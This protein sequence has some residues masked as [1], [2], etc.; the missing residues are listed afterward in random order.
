[1]AINHYKVVEGV[2]LQ[3]SY[4]RIP[5]AAAIYRVAKNHPYVSN[6]YCKTTPKGD[7]LIFMTVD[8]EIADIVKNNIHEKE[9]IAIKCHKSDNRMPEVYALR[10]DFPLGLPH[11]N[12]VPFDHPVSLCVSDVPFQD[13]RTN[14]SAFSFIELI[15]RW[16]S[17][18]AIG[19]L[20]EKD[21]P[22]EVF[23]DS[24]E[25]TYFPF[26]P[27]TN[28]NY[29]FVR[30][31]QKTNL[32]SIVEEVSERDANYCL[33][34]VPVSVNVAGY[35]HR[36]PKKLG[37]FR[38]MQ[39]SSGIPFIEAIVNAITNSPRLRRCYLPL[40]LGLI[41]PMS[42]Q[43][44]QQYEDINLFSLRLQTSSG[45]IFKKYNEFR[46]PSF[47][48]FLDDLDVHISFLVNGVSV[49]RL[50]ACSGCDS[51]INEVTFLGT[52]AL[53]SQILDHFVRRGQ[54]KILHLVDSDIMFPHNEGRHTLDV[55]DV[56][57]YKVKALK[58]K[59]Q[60]IE[61][62]KLYTYPEDFLRCS[63]QTTNRVL[64]DTELVIDAS[65]SVGVE[66]HLTLDLDKYPTR[67]CT[68]FLNPKGTDVVMLM[69]DKERY[70]RLDLLEMDYY[71]AVIKESYLDNHLDVSEKQRTNIF[72]CRA[73]SVVM[74]FDNVAV[75]A[76]IVS[77]QIPKCSAQADAQLTVWQMDAA[78][79]MVVRH[80]LNQSNWRTYK[81]NTVTVMV[82]DA[83]INEMIQQ[84]V[85]KLQNNPPVETGGT[86]LGTY[87]KDR[88]LIYVVYMIPAPDDSVEAGT[89]YIRGIDGL[90]EEVERI[91]KRTGHQIVYLGEWHSHPHH[92]SNAPSAFDQTLFGTMS[93]EMSNSDYPFVMGI[94]GDE[95]LNLI[96][97][98]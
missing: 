86:L 27:Q 28:N 7:V 73:E 20:H 29:Y 78:Q 83:V 42:R 98:M 96:A 53:G 37:E 36:I 76:S 22:M 3:P 94:L 31:T 8:S 54:A 70:H 82:S 51:S 62:L 16:F 25:I 9:P 66:R 46:K 47:D 63:E 85:Q 19:E 10:K 71:R 24:E 35:V 45:V 72:S 44:G 14:F 90:F 34:L 60:G 97:Q 58:D 18:N 23:F 64:T 61:G 1:M 69:E 81:T 80:D 75:L 11:S 5:R 15:R 57:N 74:D 52:G 30:Y 17:K 41:M 77:S 92:C 43:A 39:V 56:M 68:T 26:N 65:T 12:A 95:G 67:R 59:Y 33:L 88:N 6:V 38:D 55:S 48:K 13:L 84:R 2:E 40:M 50:G 89:S 4:I 93:T 79:G 87:D 91:K 32:S 49:D 21:R